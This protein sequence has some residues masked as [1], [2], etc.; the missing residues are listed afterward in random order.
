MGVKAKRIGRNKL[1]KGGGVDGGI[2]GGREGA[3][4]HNSPAGQADVNK[5]NQWNKIVCVYM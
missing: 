2:G 4:E 5:R 1:G 3:K